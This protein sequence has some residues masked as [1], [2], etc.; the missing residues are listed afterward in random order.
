MHR[1]REWARKMGKHQH[2]G[3][4]PVRWLPERL[5]MLVWIRAEESETES[6]E[7]EDEGGQ[8]VR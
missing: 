5:W 4:R 1:I 7:P 3:V 8:R 6:L 2:V